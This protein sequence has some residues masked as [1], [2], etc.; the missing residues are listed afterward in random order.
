GFDPDP[1]FFEAGSRGGRSRRQGSE[2]G[3]R[4]DAPAA[5]PASTAVARPAPAAK[6]AVERAAAPRRRGGKSSI[7]ADGF[8]FSTP[9][10]PSAEAVAR[11]ADEPSARAGGKPPHSRRHQR[12]LAVLL[13]GL[14]RRPDAQQ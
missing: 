14:G 7:A 3:S 4:R 5:V 11:S 1:D 13:G 6:P 9:Y 12:P 10:Q 2:G 8:D